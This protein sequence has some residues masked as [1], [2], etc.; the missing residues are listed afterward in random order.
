M[1]F[2]LN[3]LRLSLLTQ[4]KLLKIENYKQI[5]DSQETDDAVSIKELVAKVK[6]LD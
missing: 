4:G 5:L 3:Y 6:I 1:N 2:L